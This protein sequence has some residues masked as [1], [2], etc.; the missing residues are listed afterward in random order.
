MSNPYVPT[1]FIGNGVQ[2][3]PTGGEASIVAKLKG[4]LSSPLPTSLPSENVK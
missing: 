4:L 1:E 3:S 2:S